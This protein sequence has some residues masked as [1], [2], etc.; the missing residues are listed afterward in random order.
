M[1]IKLISTMATNYNG[2]I[3]KTNESDFSRMQA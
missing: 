1:T 3:G 2:I